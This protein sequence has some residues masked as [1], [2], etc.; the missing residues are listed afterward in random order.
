[1]T[2]FFSILFKRN[3][4]KFLLKS[5]DQIVLT[6]R[7]CHDNPVITNFVFL[8]KTLFGGQILH[9]F[10]HFCLDDPSINLIN[11]NWNFI[12]FRV[13]VL[14][15]TWWWWAV[16][17]VRNTFSF[18]ISLIQLGILYLKTCANRTTCCS[19]NLSFKFT[20]CMVCGVYVLYG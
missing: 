8:T 14:S 2:I 7:F 1:M 17:E 12:C 16:V 15:I 13:E 19:T 6:V 5:M 18:L 3:D 10:F 9:I 20:C 4:N 11:L